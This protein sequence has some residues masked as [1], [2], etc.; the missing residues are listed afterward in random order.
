MDYPFDLA[1]DRFAIDYLDFSFGILTT[2]IS[3]PVA[4]LLG[5]RIWWG[6]PPPY[7]FLNRSRK[8]KGSDTF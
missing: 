1:Q 2:R 6:K 7:D 5:F 3:I 8:I 4:E